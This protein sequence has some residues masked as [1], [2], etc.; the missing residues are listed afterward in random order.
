MRIFP[1]LLFFIC[2]YFLVSGADL[3]FTQET[4]SA[5]ISNW[6]IVFTI[7]AAETPSGVLQSVPAIDLDPEGNL[8]IMDSGR[9][10]LVKYSA[11]GKFLEEIGGFGQGAEE[12]SNPRDLDTHLSL[13]IFIA[14]YN[15]N[16]VVRLDARMHFLNDF[17]TSFDSPYYFEMPLSVAVNNQYDIFILEDLNKTIIKFNRF[18]EPL[19][20]FGS[21]AEN[22]GQLLGPQQLA[23]GQGNLLYVSDVLQKSV[24]VF[25]FLGNYL[26][27]IKHPDFVEPRG[28]DVSARGELIVADQKGRTVYFYDD[29]RNFFD[30]FNLASYDIR[31]TD[32]ALW[33]PK[34]KSGMRLYISD[35]Q[36]CYIFVAE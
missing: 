30:I 26:R 33:H 35:P 31:P 23:I 24:L 11:Q 10:R 8:Y 6:E 20:A 14:D 16:R 28:I 12:F 4:T 2:F 7:D 17:Q 25:D 3:L 36:K 1:S 15:N 34:G 9:N 32:V 22:L 21:A 27:E 19:T 13:N 5:G 18:S 29:S